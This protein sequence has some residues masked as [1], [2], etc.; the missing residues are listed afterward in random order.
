MNMLDKFRSSIF[1]KL[2]GI[3]CGILSAIS[4]F[5]YYFTCNPFITD[6]FQGEGA[7]LLLPAYFGALIISHLTFIL[8][9][10]IFIGLASM[11]L[12]EVAY[13]ES[14]DINY[15]NKINFITI[16]ADFG[17]LFTLVFILYAFISI[18]LRFFR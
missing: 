5:F 11:S 2:S 9:C 12:F 1:Y 7:L 6:T 8:D 3:I 14:F 18:L 15:K 17:N 10:L 16:I 13:S 4:G